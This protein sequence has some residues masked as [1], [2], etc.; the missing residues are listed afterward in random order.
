VQPADVTAGSNH[1][2]T[3]VGGPSAPASGDPAQSAGSV[4]HLPLDDERWLEL[5]RRRADATPFHHPAWAGLLADCYSRGTFVAALVREDGTV[6]AALPLVEARRIRSRRWSSLPYTDACAPLGR[7]RDVVRLLGA[8]EEE[9]AAEG[10]ATLEIRA[11]VAIEEARLATRGVLHRL[12]LDE[13]PA[14]VAASF[15]SNA[16]RSVARAE[17][18]GI[19]VRDGVRADLLGSFY[20]LHLETRRRQGVPIQPRRFFELLWERM[21]EPGLGFLL[22]AEAEGEPVAAAVFLA[23]NRTLVYKFGASDSRSWPLRPNHALFAHAIR[24]GC[25]GGYS[26]FDLGRTDGT[27]QGLRTFKSSWGATET[28]LVYSTLGDA[29]EGRLDRLGEAIAPVIRH[30]PSWVCRSLGSAFYRYAG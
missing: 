13:A 10:V 6:A 3:E 12:A 2:L 18:E 1:G 29:S 28:P 16:R 17:R 30:S 23:W 27:N 26:V 11:G 9:R 20:R 25:E 24:R 21:L 14:A 19:V 15:T 22:V 8:L 5:V 4:Q 7:D